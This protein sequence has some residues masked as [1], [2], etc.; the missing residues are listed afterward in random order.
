M[1]PNL[2]TSKGGLIFIS[3]GQVT[4]EERKLGNDVCDLVTKLT[5]HQPY[6][7]D[8]QTS[9]E[10]FTKFILGNLDRAVALIVILHP[11]GTVTFTDPQGN[12]HEQVRASVWIEQEIAIS[13]FIRQIL[14]V[15]LTVKAYVKSGITREGMREQLVLNPVEFVEE[16]E[17]LQDLTRILPGWKNIPSSIKVTAP[18]KVSVRLL[19]GIPSDFILEFTNRTEEIVHI[20]EVRFSWQGK[21]FMNPWIPVLPDSWI[22]PVGN[23]R[24]ISKMVHQEN[25]GMRLVSWNDHI[26]LIFKTDIE[27]AF[28]CELH[29]QVREVKETLRVKVF[30]DSLTQL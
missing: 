2:A 30:G 15:P 5:P 13:A 1:E 23:S 9:L 29:N 10:S 28:D 11:R 3:C 26:G 8:Q 4:T 19:K 16:S 7:A 20:R 17:V 18:P 25:P 6:F 27:I 24:S 12:P 14:N 22:V 21:T